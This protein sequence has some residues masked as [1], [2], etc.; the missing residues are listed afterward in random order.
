MTK[1]NSEFGFR[2][3]DFGN[4]F[5]AVQSGFRIP[6]SEFRIPFCLALVLLL[7]TVSLFARCP[8]SPNATLIVHAPIGNLQ[9]DTSG[10]DA[11]D[12]E[13]TNRQVTA[14]EVTC[15]PDLVE[16]EGTAPAQ[17]N[18]TADWKIRVPKTVH[19]DMVTLGGNINMGD[20]DGNVTFR[21]TG[22]SVIVGNIRGK[23]AIIT[24]GGFIKSG[25]IGG[26][27][28]LR[29]K[30]GYLE[31]GDVAG[32]AELETSGGP[33][34]AGVVVGRVTAETAGGNITIREARGD[35]I[36][37]TL[38]GDIS[39]GEARQINART[40]GGNITSRTVRG[41]FKGH[42]DSGDIRVDQVLSWIEA[43]TGQG[44]IFVK[45]VPT[46]LDGDLHVDLQTGVGDITFFMPER[47]RAT[48]DMS[49]QR[50]PFNNPR[51][52]SDFPMNALAPSTGRTLTPVQTRS[53]LNGGGNAVK[54]HTSLGAIFLRKN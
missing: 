21:T 5:H 38:A 27:A 40:A 24:Q 54:L 41:P 14:R 35:V 37:T 18:G 2:N 28:E 12:V 7:P 43:S 16:I 26:T 3:S 30:G 29:A 22:G 32:A 46:N 44:N 34:R 23:T 39:I 36:A 49:I 6:K 1:G 17:F 50:P 9:V 47:M 19:L 8:V 13:I 45:L 10:V 42:T 51:I 48:V 33:I 31:V 53:V 25:N 20:S 4:S 52:T 11:V 15:R